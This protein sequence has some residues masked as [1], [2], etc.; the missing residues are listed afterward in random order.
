MDDTDT[1]RVGSIGGKPV[2]PAPNCDTCT[3]KG[4]ALAP[5]HKTPAKCKK[6]R[7][8]EQDVHNLSRTHQPSEGHAWGWLDR[9]SYSAAFVACVGAGP[10]KVKRRTQVQQAAVKQLAGRDLVEVCESIDWYPF[11]WQNRFVRH[12]SGHLRASKY[13][14]HDW[15]TLLK[16]M[17]DN[18]E[19]RRL[20]YLSC[21][22]GPK[23]VKVLSLFVR[24]KLKI[25]AFP[26]DRHVRRLLV[27]N[28]LPTHENALVRLCADSGYDA[29]KVARSFVRQGS[30][31]TID[32]W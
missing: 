12:L 19:A 26:I 11:E 9:N 32:N 29:C 10:W 17:P 31:G 16:Q 28:Q 8:W 20:F 21:N 18:A 4:V 5:C 13:T 6:W 3:F 22:T 15:C 25:P 7:S 30:G 24:D 1:W 2:V 23:G 14:M 27:A